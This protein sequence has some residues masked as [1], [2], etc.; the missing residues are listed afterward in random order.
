MQNYLSNQNLTSYTFQ[1]DAIKKL[2]II[3]THPIQ[4]NAPF[5]KMLSERKRIAIKVFY[6]WSQSASGSKF[7]PGFKQDVEWNL[8]LFDGYEYTFVENIAAEPGSHH[9]RGINNPTLINEIQAWG[10]TEIL[11]YGWNFKSH[12]LAIRFFHNKLPVF[13][14]GDSTL[15]DEKKGLKQLLRKIALKYV[16]SYVDTAFYA[17]IANKAY[18]KAMGLKEKQLVFMPH[19]IDNSRF[20][21]NDVNIA[22]GNELREAL[23]IPAD[24][25][26]F[27]FGGKME[28]K[29]QPDFL[30]ES[31]VSLKSNTAYLILAGSGKLEKTLK[32]TYLYHPFIKF[33]GFKNQNQMPA[34]YNCC[35]VFVLPSKG[36][37]ETWGLAIN[38]A[39][40]AGKAIVAS[41]KCGG[42]YDLIQNNKNG[43]VLKSGDNT[44]LS[45]VLAFFTNNK[46]EAAKMGESSFQIIKQYSFLK[47]CYAIENCFDVTGEKKNK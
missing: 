31:F 11:V 8:P 34:V 23:N 14:R 40:A 24:A 7:D 47:D 1:A 6:T 17:G 18:F 20:A 38:E 15:I 42:S 41:D 27:L 39:M 43:F 19:A 2:A 25:V 13:F 46:S 12:W 45:R 16:Y 22:A 26:V 35:D 10:G 21:A 33:I 9:Y 29:K 37:N 28:K 44:S 30:I 4:Y 36:P 3:T 32:E 5:F